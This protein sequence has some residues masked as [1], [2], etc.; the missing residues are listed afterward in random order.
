VRGML[1]TRRLAHLPHAISYGEMPR[2]GLSAI[3]VWPASRKFYFG[4]LPRQSLDG[5]TG[6]AGYKSAQP[7]KKRFPA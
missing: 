4:Q 6:D 5:Q 7:R 3:G 2:F 1:P